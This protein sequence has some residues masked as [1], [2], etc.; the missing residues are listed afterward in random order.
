MQREAF[1]QVRFNWNPL[2][3]DKDSFDAPPLTE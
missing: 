2:S 1:A 3:A